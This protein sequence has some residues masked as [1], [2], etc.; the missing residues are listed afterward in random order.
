LTCELRLQY[1]QCRCHSSN[2]PLNY[3]NYIF[4]LESLRFNWIILM[5]ALLCQ[6]EAAFRVHGKL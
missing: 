5:M 2:I 6:T 4:R 3:P 1:I